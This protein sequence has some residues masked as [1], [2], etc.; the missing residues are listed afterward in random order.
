M[1]LQQGGT[2]RV[3][4]GIALLLYTYVVSCEPAVQES[5]HHLSAISGA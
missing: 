1:Y 5:E 2:I 3:I 4:S